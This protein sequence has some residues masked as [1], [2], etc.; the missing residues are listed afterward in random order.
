MTEPVASTERVFQKDGHFMDWKFTKY[1][2]QNIRIPE[3]FLH[4]SI[5]K[6]Q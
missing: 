5:Q 6:M 2:K 4:M 1:I 3:K